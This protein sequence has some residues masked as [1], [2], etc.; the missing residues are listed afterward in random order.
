MDKSL[1]GRIERLER[2]AMDILDPRTATTQQLEDYLTEVLGHWPTNAD[3]ERLIAE[4]Q[5]AGE[6]KE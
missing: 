1:I 3:L 4:A 5:A 2:G 6:R